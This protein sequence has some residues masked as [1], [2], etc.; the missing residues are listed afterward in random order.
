MRAPH[1]TGL[2][3]L[4]ILTRSDLQDHRE[5][6]RDP[7]RQPST[8]RLDATGGSTGEPVRFY[9]DQA[10]DLTTFCTEL[11]M[12]RWW[13]VKPWDRIAYVWGDD[14]ELSQIPRRQRVQERLLGRLHLNAF[15]IDDAGIAHFAKTLRR[16]RPKIL[17][18][19][20]TAL[21]LLACA[22]SCRM[23]ARPFAR[24]WCV[25]RRSRSFRIAGRGSKRH[26]VSVCAMST[27]RG[28]APALAAEC[29]AG[30]FHVMAHA[31]VI[32]LVDDQGQAVAP[33]TPGRV[34]IT[35]LANTAFGFLRYE[36]GDVASW[37]EDSSPCACGCAYP[38]LKAVHGRSSDF[39]STPAGRRIHGEWFTHLFYGRDDVRRFQLRQTALDR[40]H[41]LTEGPAQGATLDGLLGQI[42][43][44]LGAGVT[45]TWERVDRIDPGV[46]GKHRFTVS[47]VPFL[48]TATHS[49]RS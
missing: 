12:H 30:S 38:R 1:A 19:Y 25:P 2:S 48:A 32:E 20:A 28:R 47:E 45:L 21:D 41:L 40:V 44:R 24:A 22:M 34:L 8:L 49:E 46:S 35:D 42:R 15:S 17:Q 39:I 23:E 10:Y 18:G 6:L 33:G 43:E 13:G 36:N 14:R 3:E 11:L 27:D 16:F 29:T 9:H 26:S 4:P 7:S 5:A 37:D 31:K